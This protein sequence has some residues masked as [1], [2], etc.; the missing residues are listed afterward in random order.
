MNESWIKEIQKRVQGLPIS[1][2]RSK[3]WGKISFDDLVFLPAQLLKRPVDYYREKIETK[4]IIGK[5]SQKPIELETPIIIG[6][7]SFGSLDRETKA[8]LALA[9]KIAGSCTNTGEG[10]MLPEER[11]YSQ[12]LISQYASARFGIDEKYFQKADAIE[13]KIGQG[14]KAG[15]GGYLPGFKVTAEIAEIRKVPVGKDIHSLA[16]HPDIKTIDDLRKKMAELREKTGG[17]PIIL[18]LGGPGPEDIKLAVKANPDIIAIDGMEG[19]C[20]TAPEVLMDEVGIPTIAAL[21]GARKVLDEM[22]AKQE[23]WIGGGLN[24]GG[25]IA[26]ALALGA[27]GVFLATSLLVAMG[28]PLEKDS[29]KRIFPEVKPEIETKAQRIASFIKNCTEEI[30]MIAGASGENNIHN[31]NKGHLR[32]LN[33]E[34]AKIT[35]VKLVP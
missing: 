27:D 35:G 13:I 28:T 2:G 25:D 7:M 21:V 4:T 11:E 31:L 20:G 34:I 9:S 3:K 23:L 18:K 24:K 1:G 29:K 19:G 12:C 17:K 10:G 30:K 6:A 32:A 8:A 26:K 16:A 33:S 22:G 15:A 14:A 5:L